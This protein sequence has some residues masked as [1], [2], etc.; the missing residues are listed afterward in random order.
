MA[1]VPII[2]YT[3][4]N[5]SDL[6][7]VVDYVESYVRSTEGSVKTRQAIQE[8]EFNS[9]TN[10]IPSRVR[11]RRFRGA[12]NPSEPRAY[13]GKTSWR[14]WG[15]FS[16]VEPQYA[17]SSEI[18]WLSAAASDTPTAPS[19]MVEAIAEEL[20]QRYQISW[21]RTRAPMDTSDLRLRI[22]G[23]VA[24]KK[25][26]DQR[27]SDRLGK[28]EQRLQHAMYAL[29]RSTHYLR[30]TAVQ[31]GTARKHMKDDEY[32]S[33]DFHRR[34]SEL[35]RLSDEA[36]MVLTACLAAVKAERGGDNA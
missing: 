11:H 31:L 7:A 21:S 5:T 34:L 28:A 12:K 17:F 9:F 3:R 36:D 35:R 29:H 22:E 32:L 25:S 27:R 16:L 20:L 18:E 23:A 24:A 30:S 2:N 4:Y 1:I 15:R 8:L 26:K 14:N 13:L 10:G 6:V 33:D 19:E